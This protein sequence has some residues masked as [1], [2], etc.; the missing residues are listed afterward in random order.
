MKKHYFQL[1][2]YAAITAFCLIFTFFCSSIFVE[3][4]GNHQNI[5]MVKTYILYGVILLI[6]T[7]ALTGFTG[8]KLSQKIRSKFIDRKQKRMPII[9]INGLVVLLPCAFYLQYLASYG[10][11]NH[12]FYL[13]QGLELIAGFTN[14]T[15]MSFSILDMKKSKYNH[16]KISI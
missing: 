7:M 15:L 5:L 1:H 8:A 6:P 11:F 9:A 12:M 2:R 3:L 4:F 13:I 10:L 16:T 14:L